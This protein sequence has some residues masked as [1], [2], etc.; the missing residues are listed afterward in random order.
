[1]EDVTYRGVEGDGIFVAGDHIA[2]HLFHGLV[3]FVGLVVGE[4]ADDESA[5]FR[6]HSAELQLIEYALYFIYWLGD[7]FDEEYGAGLYHVVGCVDEFGEDGEV[8][9]DER[10][11]FDAA[12]VEFVRWEGVDG[13][14]AAED[15]EKRGVVGVAVAEAYVFGHRAVDA[16]DTF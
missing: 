14:L 13:S 11:C 9:A 16:G 15:G 10:A 5:E 7:V 1:M 3:A 4:L 12:A 6:E 8:A 2:D